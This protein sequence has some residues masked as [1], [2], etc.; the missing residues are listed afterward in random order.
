M[1]QNLLQRLNKIHHK[2]DWLGLRE[3]KEITRNYIARN[4]KIEKN[5]TNI[6]HGCMVEVLLNGH[7]AYCGAA[8]M[9]DEALQK[10]CDRATLL[11]QHTASWKT[12][13][14]S[15]DHRPPSVG[16]YQTQTPF[17][18]DKASPGEIMSLL[19]NATIK[20]KVSDK[21]VNCIAH[22]MMIETEITLASSTGAHI[23][24]QFS[25]LAPYL[26]ATAQDGTEIQNRSVSPCHQGGL[27]LLNQAELATEAERIGREAVELLTAEQCPTGVYDVILAP[28]QLYLQIHESIGHPL[29]LDRILGDE[30]N[31]A[32]W[33]FV[34]LSDFGHLQYGSSLLNIVFDPTVVGE[35]A[36]YHFDDAGIPATRE[37]LIKDGLLLRGIG[38]IDSQKRGNIPGV[39]SMRAQSWNRPPIDRMANINL[40]P[41]NSSFSEMIG[42]VERGIYMTTNTCWSIDDYRNK[43]QFGC[44]YAKL[45]ENGKLTKTIKNPNYRGVTAPFWNNL[46][47]V[48][49]AST[50][51]VW[52]NTY[53]GKG[54]PNQVIR[55]GHATPPCLFGNVDV[56]G[57]A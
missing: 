24:Q 6:D 50:F 51:E 45:I 56:F 10:A 54:E 20:M 31:Y 47:M 29:E 35:Y 49:D 22:A 52:G 36:S 1:S 14:A 27:E 11:A 48:G 12:F 30:R 37:Y 57:G 34:Q 40:E 42:S 43:F 28:D 13:P 55:V 4:G 16:T 33:S 8:N 7:F 39:S 32:G 25:S 2:V 46:K 26:R 15:L 17:P 21:I 44:E 9:T 3:V 18:L 19:I 53:C 5:T 38:G 41:G 23:H